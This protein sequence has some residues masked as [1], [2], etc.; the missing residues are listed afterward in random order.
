MEALV[1]VIVMEECFN[2]ASLYYQTTLSLDMIIP[3]DKNTVTSSSNS[4][5]ELEPLDKPFEQKH[6]RRVRYPTPPQEKRPSYEADDFDLSL[7]HG[8]YVTTDTRRPSN[9][10]SYTMNT[11]IVHSQPLETVAASGELHQSDSSESTV[12]AEIKPIR[13]KPSQRRGCLSV[14]RQLRFFQ[15]NKQRK[16]HFHSF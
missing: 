8:M 14:L 2:P 1:Y 16:S 4:V 3:V 6:T 12:V 9:T 15:P 10:S 13:T 5:A 11:T 7:L